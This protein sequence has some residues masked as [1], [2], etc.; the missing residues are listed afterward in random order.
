M[1]SES[2]G[3]AT[4]LLGLLR[5]L[6]GSPFDAV[7]L[8]RAISRYRDGLRYEATGI[9]PALDALEQ[10]CNLIVAGPRK[11]TEGQEGSTLPDPGPASDGHLMPDTLLDLPQAAAR[12]SISP[13]TVKRRA[14]SGDLPAVRHGRVVR[15]RVSDID[16][17]LN[18]QG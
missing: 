3:A 13:S 11:V 4:V 8:S 9:P 6:N 17:Y 1:T 2:A 10:L 18:G 15:Y 14:M 12:M 7:H 16:N 5:M